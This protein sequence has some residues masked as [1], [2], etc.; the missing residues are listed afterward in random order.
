[1]EQAAEEQGRALRSLG[2]DVN[3][4]PVCDVVQ[5]GE[6]GVIGDRSF[7][8]EPQ[9][10]GR[11]S[12]AFVRGALRGGVLPC[13]KHFPG[14]GS[15]RVDSH[16][17]LPVLAKSFAE[18]EALDLLPFAAA[19]AAGVPLVMSAHLVCP[20]LSSGPATLCHSWITG[21]LRGRL[22]FSGVVVTDDLEMG[23]LDGLDAPAQ[24]ALRA[25]RAGCD[26]LLYGRVLRPDLD[27]WSVAEVVEREILDS[28]LNASLD[29]ISKLSLVLN[30]HRA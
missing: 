22:G 7:G 30:D 24:V 6:S 26:L 16:K 12:A 17:G 9:A 25:H 19:A 28:E 5:E 1:V 15:A 8:S 20:G 21:I 13:A 10:V 27:L 18:V 4:A 2:I 11:L 29:R 23:A 14:H 3:L